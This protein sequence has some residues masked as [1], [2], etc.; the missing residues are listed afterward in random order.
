MLGLDDEIDGGQ[1]GRCLRT[2]DHHHLGRSG[3]GRR[4]AHHSGHLA[5]GFG[6]IAVAGADDDID[7]L[8]RLGPIGHGPD[9]L[10]PAH[11]VHLAHA[12]HRGR[13]QRGVVDPAVRPGRNAQDDLVDAGDLGGHRTHE[14]RRRIAGATTGRVT[15][16]AGHRAHQMPHLDATGLEVLGC[17]SP[18]S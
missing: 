1:L 6:H 18:D 13:R 16:G 4:H 9:G 17:E 2:C 15:P 11:P 3:E 10:G 5:L 8:D 12:G 14:H 7:G